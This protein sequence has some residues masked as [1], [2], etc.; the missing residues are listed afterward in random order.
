MMIGEP[1]EPGDSL[2]RKAE[3]NMK[4]VSID[5][6][7]F[8]TYGISFVSGKNFSKQMKTGGSFEEQ[9]ANGFILSESAVKLL[10]WG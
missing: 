3:V 4:N 8:D 7:F 9:V 5:Q 2:V 6:H 1:I 10:G